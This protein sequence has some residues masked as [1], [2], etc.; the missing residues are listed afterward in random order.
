MILVNQ[1]KENKI[2]YYFDSTVLPVLMFFIGKQSFA[3]LG[4]KNALVSS[5]N[6]V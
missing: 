5:A 4:T 2:S 3:N 6:K 1:Q